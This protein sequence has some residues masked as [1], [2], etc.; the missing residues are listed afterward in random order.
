METTKVGKTK[1]KLDR[2][3]LHTTIGHQ[4]SHLL[5]QPFDIQLQ[6]DRGKFS[7]IGNDVLAI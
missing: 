5:L 7:F 6:E 1:E 3:T 4:G 2:K